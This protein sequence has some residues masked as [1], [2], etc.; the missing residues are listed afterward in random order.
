MLANDKIKIQLLVTL[1]IS[2]VSKSAS[3]LSKVINSKH[4]TVKNALEFLLYIDFV[5][6]FIEKHG[7][8]EYI[9]YELTKTG[10]IFI[11]KKE[12]KKW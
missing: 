9:Y 3:E 11:T 2:N 8:K 10:K 1:N 12:G 5:K 6:S 4:E 7:N